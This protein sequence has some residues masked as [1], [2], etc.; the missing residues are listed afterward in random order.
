M[1]IW[2]ERFENASVVI[3]YKTE[4]IQICWSSGKYPLL[5]VIPENQTIQYLEGL[6]A[7]CRRNIECTVQTHGCE[8]ATKNSTVEAGNMHHWL[9]IVSSSDHW[10]CSYGRIFSSYC[11]IQVGGKIIARSFDHVRSYPTL[12][13]F[14]DLIQVSSE[15]WSPTFDCW[16]FYS[17]LC[18]KK[19]SASWVCRLNEMTCSWL[20][21]WGL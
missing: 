8:F 12:V 7:L 18:G 20:I 17:Q 5:V 14:I 11:K 15:F 10:K 13:W 6:L 3:F 9:I 4:V 16:T 19:T 21:I 2:V 1:L